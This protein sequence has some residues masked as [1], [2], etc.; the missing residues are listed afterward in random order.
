MPAWLAHFSKRN[1][2]PACFNTIAVAA[3]M[4]GRNCKDAFTETENKARSCATNVWSD[5]LRWS[6]GWWRRSA[7]AADERGQARRRRLH[8]QGKI[9][10]ALA[11]LVSRKL[12]SRAVNPRI[13]GKCWSANPDRADAPMRRSWRVHWTQS[14]L[15]GTAQ[16]GRRA[17]LLGHIDRLTILPRKCSTRKK[18]LS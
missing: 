18:N 17:M 10:R 15:A 11:G 5:F 13:I 12:V 16:R 4:E 14:P 9:S 7:P 8:G 2:W 1:V 6:S 3:A